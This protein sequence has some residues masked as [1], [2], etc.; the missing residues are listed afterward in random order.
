MKKILALILALVMV[1]TLSATAAATYEGLYAKSTVVV[2]INED[3]D[4]VVV[5]DFNGF[6]WEFEG[7]EDWVVGDICAMVMDNNGTP[8]TIFDD[9]ILNT[10]Y[11]GWVK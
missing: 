4:I 5:E 10:T 8:E 7:C 11:C 6:L 2:E 1:L 9:I 3:D